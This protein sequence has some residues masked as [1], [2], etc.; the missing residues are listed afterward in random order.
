MDVEDDNSIKSAYESVCKIL[1][2]DTGLNLL[3][4]NAGIMDKNGSE[5]P[6]AE[7]KSYQHHFNVNITGAVMVTQV[8]V[9]YLD[10]IIDCFFINDCILNKV[11]YSN[12]TKV[13]LDNICISGS[14]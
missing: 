6:G 1:P 9:S 2:K 10:D 5:F 4:N 13:T 3:I 11:I 14:I 8:R 7:R 12:S